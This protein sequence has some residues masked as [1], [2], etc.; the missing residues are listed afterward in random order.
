MSDGA[1]EA[2]IVVV[3]IRLRNGD[4]IKARKKDG[5]GMDLAGVHRALQDSE[6]V[7]IGDDTIIRS[8]DVQSI[9]VD[10]R[11]SG[12]LVDSLLSK[13]G[14][15][16]EEGDEPERHGVHESRPSEQWQY[17]YVPTETKPFFLT[18]EFVL[19]FVAWLALLLTSL[20]T[21][22]V[23]AWT[24]SFLSIAIATGYMVS[25]GFAKANS[26][27]RGFDPREDWQPGH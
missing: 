19:A 3:E 5:D 21:D 4:T 10:S 8:A 25:R 14:G 11:S 9:Q 22:S 20:A 26:P 18:S 23:D 15:G 6:F 17:S 27:S 13:V 2:D 1:Q 7:Q 16:R 12:G 24:F